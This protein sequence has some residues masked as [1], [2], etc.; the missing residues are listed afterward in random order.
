MLMEHRT[1][2]GLGAWLAARRPGHSLP[3]PL[4][5]SED[6][7]L[8]DCDAIFS[9]H[10]V[11]VGLACDV[12]EAGDVIALDI[13]PSS[14]VIL[15]DEEDRLRAFHNVCSHRGARLVPPGRSVVGKLVCPYH[16]WTY[17]LDGALALAPH[18]GV[19]F[20]RG[21]HHLKPVALRDVGGILYACLSDDPPDDID[22]LARVMEP[23]LAPYDLRNAR[24]AHEQDVIEAGNWKLTME[25]NRECYHCASKHPQL[26]LSFHAADFGYD[27]D[28][29]S[30]GERAE[31]DALAE[32][33]RRHGAHWD[34]EG[35]P[36]AAVEHTVG[37][38]TN[39]RTQRLIIAGLGESQ[40]PDTRAA[41]TLPLG[42]QDRPWSGDMHL[43]G[44]NSWNHVMS[45][46]AVVFAAYP[47]GPDRT[48]VRTKWLVHRDAVEGEDYDL[49]NLTAVW[50]ATNAEDAHL[51]ALAHRG[52]A[53]AGYRPGP[54]SRF[55]ERA[56]D[57]FSTW[58]VD[59]MTAHGYAG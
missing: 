54:Y 14:I 34:A 5:T 2:D 36:H 8:A 49:D 48:L 39:F 22:E 27:P 56:L 28:G 15:R 29:L 1:R 50:R 57:E 18:M 41:V 19:D 4:Y 30:D 38:P 3:A 44:I 40:T 16:Q 51:V 26:S 59:R 7:W 43:W 10:W 25:N 12:E 23:R 17:D 37:W 9:R 20:P 46:H 24:V 45:D 58:Y 35:L 13:G 21:L 33:Y 55:T 52:V 32:A 31:S 6:A 42:G 11:A 53:S 47:L